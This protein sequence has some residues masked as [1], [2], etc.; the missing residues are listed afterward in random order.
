MVTLGGPHFYCTCC[1]AAARPTAAFA[2]DGEIPNAGIEVGRIH[3]EPRSRPVQSSVRQ[4]TGHGRPTQRAQFDGVT[5][6]SGGR[7]VADA[8]ISN[9]WN[10]EDRAFDQGR[11]GHPTVQA[12]PIQPPPQTSPPV[13]RPINRKV[14]PA[15]P[16]ARGFRSTL[17]RPSGACCA[18]RRE[19]PPKRKK[20]PR[21]AELPR[22]QCGKSV[23]HLI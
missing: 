19:A 18:L 13:E 22:K 15:A 14:G 21:L 1:R 9:K 3:M 10:A 2:M 11:G 7:W 6:R 23:F 17:H 4:F 20:K 16:K 12:G 5:R 8:N